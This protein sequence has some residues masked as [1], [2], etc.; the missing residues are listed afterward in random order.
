MLA[1][2]RRFTV[3]GAL[4]RHRPG[5]QVVRNL[6][7]RHPCDFARRCPVK[8]SKRTIVPKGE[9]VAPVA[10]QISAISSSLNTRSRL[11]LALDTGKSAKGFVCS[12]PRFTAQANAA[13]P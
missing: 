10:R 4:A 13:R 9:R 12:M 1:N 5:H 11:T 6:A 7:P 8:M 2:L 3:L